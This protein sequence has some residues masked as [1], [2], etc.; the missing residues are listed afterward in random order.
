[1]FSYPRISPPY[2]YRCAF[3]HTPETCDLD[4]AEDLDRAI[5]A[6]GEELI[7]AFIF[8]PVIGAAAPGVAPPVGY[9]QRIREI[10]ESH[11]VLLI[12]DEVMS[13][14]GRTG[15]F[16]ASQ[17]YQA[18][19]HMICLSKGLSSGYSP[20]GAVMVENEVYDVLKESAA[21]SFIH[22]HTFG[23]NPLSAAVGLEVLKII[24][25]EDLVDHVAEMG[26][27]WLPKL[28]ALKN[29]YRIIGDVRGK[30]LMIG[31][32]FVRDRRSGKS[33][34]DPTLNLRSRMQEE[35]LKRGLYVYPGGYS[36]RGRAG[37][38]ILLAPPYIVEKTDIDKMT[39]IIEEAVAEIE[40][41]YS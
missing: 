19:P 31:I 39:D 26:D 33:P 18:R 13:G 28:E 3:Y 21:H 7:S 10:C 27:Y 1:L 34:F 24:Q 8:E 25:E 35:C 30:G 36:V 15:K 23:G 38:H 12:G 40:K 11:G 4:C 9:L 14:V 22:G 37:D 41:S 17:H 29:K 5:I 2:C 32:E 16:L 6:E 20:L